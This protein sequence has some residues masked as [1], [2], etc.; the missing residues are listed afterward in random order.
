MMKKDK[1]IAVCLK[2]SKPINDIK[3][4]DCTRSCSDFIEGKKCP[5][6]TTLTESEIKRRW[7]SS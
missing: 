2:F 3:P 7:G 1:E 5:D 4:E 6:F